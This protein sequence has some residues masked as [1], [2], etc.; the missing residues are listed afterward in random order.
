MGDGGGNLAPTDR[1]TVRVKVTNT[2]DVGEVVQIYS[3]P[4]YYRGGIEKSR[5][6]LIGFGSTG[7]LKPNESEEV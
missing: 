7:S 4:P 1:V 2:G 6:E 3:Q 5:V